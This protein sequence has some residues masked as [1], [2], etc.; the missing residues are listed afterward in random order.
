MSASTISPIAGCSATASHTHGSILRCGI[1]P[2]LLPSLGS[3]AR[4]F[5]GR[6]RYDRFI[7]T[8]PGD[9]LA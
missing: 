9:P 4:A 2:S 8:A 7:E 1:G 3:A 6:L 5:G